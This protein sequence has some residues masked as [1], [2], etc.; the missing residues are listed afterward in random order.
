MGSGTHDSFRRAILIL[1]TEIFTADVYW[2]VDSFIFILK[3]SFYFRSYLELF[4]VDS[5]SLSESERR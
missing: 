2:Y 3:V 5:E 4:I 1:Q